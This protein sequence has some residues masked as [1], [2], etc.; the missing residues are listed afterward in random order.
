VPADFDGQPVLVGGVF[1]GATSV[2][3]TGKT[4]A[5][6]NRIAIVHV[7]VGDGGGSGTGVSSVTYGGVDITAN[8][9]VAQS[10][11][12]SYAAIYYL[13]NPPAGATDIVVNF[14]APSFGDCAV[15][16]FNG[17]DQVSPIRNT[18]SATATSNTASTSVTSAS[19]DM[20]VD[21]IAATGASVAFTAGAGQTQLVGFSVGDNQGDGSYKAATSA[22][23]TMT[24]TAGSNYLYGLAAACLSQVASPPAGRQQS[25]SL[26][27]CG[28]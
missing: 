4:T 21:A 7:G 20:V 26:L 13:V 28:V 17:V 12:H 6:S 16:S 5:G 24:W 8:L 27:G 10:T 9:A 25:L 18:N 22:S 11:A 23:T 15:A 14:T 1:S 3:L 2:T 19:G